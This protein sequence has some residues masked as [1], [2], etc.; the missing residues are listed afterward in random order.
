LVISALAFRFKSPMFQ[1]SI[2]AVK[3]E[4]TQLIC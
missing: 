4:I 1:A 3:S 2:L